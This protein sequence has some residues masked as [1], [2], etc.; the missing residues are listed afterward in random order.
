MDILKRYFTTRVEQTGDRTWK[1]IISDESL[2]RHNT[3][4]KIDG[5]KLENYINNNV[6]FYNHYTGSS[7]PDLNVGKGNVYVE[8]KNLIGIA[9]L[10]PKGN[11]PYADKLQNKLEFGNIKCTS[12]GFM[13]I[14]ARYGDPKLGEDPD[15]IY[16]LEQELYE[17]SIVD[18]PSNVNATLQKSIDKSF[19]DYISTI[20]KSSGEEPPKEITLPTP[21]PDRYTTDYLK[22]KRAQL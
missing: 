11:N 19:D 4:I 17:F 13:P 1:F 3:K 8:E 9:E 12:V 6:V 7:N 14:S 20:Q 16:F 10:E 21:G 2:D 22:F 5:W 18:I 15:V